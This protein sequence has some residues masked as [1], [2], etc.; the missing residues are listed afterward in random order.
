MSA[1]CNLCDPRTL[2]AE[3]ELGRHLL[4]AH[5]FDIDKEVAR[6]PDGEPVIV[7]VDPEP[8]DFER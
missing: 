1:Y 4:E 7:D 6:W 5:D 2:H 8:E 3:E